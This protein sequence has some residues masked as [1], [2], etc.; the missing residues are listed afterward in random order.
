MNSVPFTEY[1]LFDPKG[2][3]CVSHT[4][5]SQEPPLPGGTRWT[6]TLSFLPN[7]DWSSESSAPTL[8][9]VADLKDLAVYLM[10]D[11]FFAVT[12]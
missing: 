11:E 4:P 10:G 8:P 9:K 5:V 2:R 3:R 6:W 1:S 7:H 12:E